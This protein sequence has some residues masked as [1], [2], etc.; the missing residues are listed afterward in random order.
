MIS[1]EKSVGAVVFRRQGNT[2]MFLLLHYRSG[3]WDFPKGH[4]ESGETE[5]GTLMREVSEESGLNDLE[6][7]PE[8]K[9]QTRFFYRAGEEEKQRR[10]VEGRYANIAKKV[11]YYIA[12]TKTKNIMISFEH[13]G[14][15]WLGY[16]DAL[17]RITYGNSKNVL[18]KANKHLEAL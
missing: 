7:L 10:K 12:E 5:H 16:A 4:M 8:F 15:E 2:I 17:S 3:H 1:F 6:I 11:V 14:F 9:T 18:K 13:I